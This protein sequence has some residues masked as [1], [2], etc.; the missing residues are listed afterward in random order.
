MQN[1]RKFT[2]PARAWQRAVIIVSLALLYAAAFQPLTTFIGPVGAALVA[3]PIA[4]TGWLFGPMAGFFAGVAG[5]GLNAGLFFLRDGMEGITW[6]LAGWPVNLMIVAAGYSVGLIER[7]LSER[8][9]IEFELSSRERFI[10][11]MGLAARDILDPKTAQDKYYYLANHLA[12]LFVA[13]YVY[14]CQWNIIQNRMTLLA[15]TKPTGEPTT[16]FSLE[17]DRANPNSTYLGRDQALVITG[18]SNSQ[19]IV[20]LSTLN[21]LSLPARSEFALPLVAGGYKFGVVV[22]GFTEP[23]HISGSDIIFAQLTSSQIALA[24]W[25]AEQDAQIKKQLREA[26]TLSKIERALSETE[27]IGIETL[28]QLIVDSAKE[29]IPG[30]EKVVLHLV[31]TEN[32]VLMPRAIAG[33]KAASSRAKLN[34]R[35]GEGIAGQVISSG[36]SI[37]IS[38]IHA[39]P[40]FIHQ[41]TPVKYRSLIVAPIKKSQD[42]VVGTISIDSEQSNAFTPD[43]ERLLNALGVQAAIAIE[44]TSLLETTRQDLQEINALYHISRSLTATLDPDHLIRDITNLLHEI[45]GYYHIQVFVAD[46]LLGDLMVRHASGEQ[47]AVFMEEGHRIAIGAGIIG[48][49]AELGEPF[50]TNNVEAVVFFMRHPL[51]PDTQSELTVPIK[52]DGKVLG[53]L[54]IQEK[55]PR[56]F[57]QRQMSLMMAVADQLAVALQKATLYQELQASL[58]QEKETRAQLIQSE[59]LALVG[60]LLASVSHE[61]NNPLQA[62]QNALFLVKEDEQLSGQGKQDLDIIL[63]ETERMA[64]LIGRLRA[65]YRATQAE[66]FQDIWLNDVIED[67]HALTSTYMRH[68]SI[69]FTF[70]P[71]PELPAAPVIPDKIRQVILNLFMNAIEAMQSG[72]ELTIHTYHLPEQ[73][74]VLITFTDTG[75][76][77]NPEIQSRIFEPFVT[78]KAAGTGLGLTIT[79]DIIH[80]HRGEIQAEN[81]NPGAGAVFKIWLPT[82]RDE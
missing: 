7:G 10:S 62:I 22:F 79:A 34:M 67:V 26:S 24:L 6:L 60:R 9:R 20:K 19:A 35:L 47:A 37:S 42:D 44:N 40:R 13:D 46:P 41:T 5:L 66:D 28:L 23:R 12:N 14:L 76:G 59:R 58:R 57:S 82:R 70:H 56:Q 11:I 27:K 73:E 32:Q 78:D 75:P 15:T 69:V 39:D 55:P 80:Q 51:L 8:A 65:T 16:N 21:E 38:D 33:V 71:D 74:R 72:G 64:S 53:V 77:I 63:S 3:I 81:N 48:H 1:L 50:V 45:F 25:T 68:R 31:D 18:Q 43:D 30:A 52:I 17:K 49:V 36:N 54:D 2:Q 61:L 4:A 29:L